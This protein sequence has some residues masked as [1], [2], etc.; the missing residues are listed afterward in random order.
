MPINNWPV[1]RMKAKK[2][3]RE[4]ANEISL[5]REKQQRGK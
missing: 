4:N 5:D 2:K 1:S 3:K